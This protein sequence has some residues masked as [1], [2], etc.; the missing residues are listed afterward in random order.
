MVNSCL[1]WEL[2]GF[3]PEFPSGRKRGLICPQQEQVAFTAAEWNG[4]PGSDP[5]PKSFHVKRDEVSVICSNLR[6]FLKIQNCLFKL[7]K[8]VEELSLEPI[9][10]GYPQGPSR[11][12]ELQEQSLRSNYQHRDCPSRQEAPSSPDCSL[13]LSW[14]HFFLLIAPGY[15]PHQPSYHP[16]SLIFSALPPT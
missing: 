1:C 14:P 13:G 9:L 4:K 7:I 3:L 8:V 10:H 11:A 2:F 6:S 12:F 16:A 15:L 5:R